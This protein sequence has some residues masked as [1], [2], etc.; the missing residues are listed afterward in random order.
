MTIDDEV[1]GDLLA[2]GKRMRMAATVVVVRI[3][4]VVIEGRLLRRCPWRLDGL[5]KVQ[6]GC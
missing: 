2:K 3:V 1:K 6:Q 5:V 4:D